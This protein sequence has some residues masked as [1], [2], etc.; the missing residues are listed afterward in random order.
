MLLPYW[1]RPLQ[2][3]GALTLT[4]TSLSFFVFLGVVFTAYW[5]SRT[6]DLQKWVLL[7]ASYAFY[8]AFDA[9]FCL[10]LGMSSLV[11][12]LFGNA[13]SSARSPRARRA[14]LGAGVL[15][16]LLTLGFFKYLDFFASGA[17]RMMNALGWRAD[18]LTVR[19]LVPVGVSFFLFKIVS[20]LIDLYRSGNRPG[21]ALDFGVYI[22]FF[23]QLLAGPIERASGFLVQLRSRRDFDYALAVA[24]SRQVLWG[25]FKKLAIADGLALIVNRVYSQWE[26]HSGPALSVAAALYSF[27][28][29]CDF[30]GYTDISIGTSKLLGIRTMRNFAYPYF[31]QNVAEFWRRWNISVSSWFRDYVYIPLG[32]SR[33]RPARWAANILLTFLASGLWHGANATFLVWGLVLGGA[34]AFTS[35]R[36]VPVLSAEDTPGGE[37]ITP[38]AAARMLVTFGFVSLAWVFFRSDSVEMALGIVR[39]ILTPALTQAAWLEALMLV[40]GSALPTVVVLCAFVWFEW[41]QRRHDCA[42]DVTVESRAYRWAT[43]SAIVWLTLLLM[44]P[45]LSG[46][47][48]YFDF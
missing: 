26:L 40:S 16:N 33:V 28:L 43:Y 22:A 38:G 19:V 18:S 20:Y 5:M 2:R 3:N 45:Q 14:W 11:G 30:S 47:F 36:R 9:R 24:G 13:L 39:T 44:Q 41:V 27:Q 37:R 31:S 32:G 25:L 4:L 8:A 15:F 6:N 42:L 46:R 35:L 21:K 1:L 34:V 12:F 48:V 29:Y 17:V 23:P 10:L 7:V